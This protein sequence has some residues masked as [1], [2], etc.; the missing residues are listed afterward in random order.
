VPSVAVLVAVVVVLVDDDVDE[1][2]VAL[3]VLAPPPP[4]ASEQAGSADE[5]ARVRASGSARARRAGMTTS[6]ARV[7]GPARR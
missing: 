7:G 6:G 3:V 5:R 4:S 1:V 2:V